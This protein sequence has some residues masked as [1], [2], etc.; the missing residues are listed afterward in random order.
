LTV[1]QG[2]LP[3]RARCAP[4]PGTPTR[5]DER[6]VLA[7]SPGLVSSRNNKGFAFNS[8]EQFMRSH[9]SLST[10]VAAAVLGAC[11]ST[12][13]PGG[14]AYYTNTGGQQGTQ[15]GSDTGGTSQDAAST[16]SNNP[17]PGSG[18]SSGTATDTSSS[19]TK[20]AAGIG[21]TTAKCFGDFSLM[22]TPF[23]SSDASQ[24]GAKCDAKIP[25]NCPKG[26]SI[27][28]KDTGECICI[29][30]CNQFAKPIQVGGNCNE[31]GSWKC[32]E[33][34]SS[35]GNNKMKACVA[36]SWGLC[37]TG[38]STGT[39]GNTGTTTADAGSTGTK[40]TSTGGTTACNKKKSGQA[41]TFDSDC[42]S[43]NCMIGD[44]VCE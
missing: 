42:C 1:V 18:G 2:C 11:A 38:G 36:E 40:D 30:G 34:V 25:K 22:S 7:P 14:G 17:G 12:P 24:I 33:I 35:D 21:T 43:G 5:R 20:D 10:V 3:V 39:G 6:K 4:L 13:P 9:L 8:L 19:S 37:N 27:V 44:D 32:R 41:C 15:Q 29:I 26:E 23:S 16:G 28:F 31:S